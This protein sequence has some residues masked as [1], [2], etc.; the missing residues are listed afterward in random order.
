MNRPLY[1]P[2][3]NTLGVMDWVTPS[4]RIQAAD[5]VFNAPNREDDAEV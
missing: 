3:L 2:N 5:L 4:I 1:L